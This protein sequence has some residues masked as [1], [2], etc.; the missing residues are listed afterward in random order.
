MDTA[1]TSNYTNTR[2]TTAYKPTTFTTGSITTDNNTAN[3]ST[4]NTN[5]NR[6]NNTNSNSNNNLNMTCNMRDIDF[7]MYNKFGHTYTA[8][9]LY[10]ITK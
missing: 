9:M 8:I 10:A 1:T 3:G 6:S 5:T 2:N 4:T 7:A